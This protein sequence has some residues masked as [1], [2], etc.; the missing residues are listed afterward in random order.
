ML[1]VCAYGLILL[2]GWLCWLVG[3]VVWPYWINM[4]PRWLCYQAGSPG[5][6]AMLAG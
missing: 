3:Y 4:R 2:A 6:L 5:R 1:T